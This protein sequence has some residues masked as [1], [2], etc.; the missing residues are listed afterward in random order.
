MTRGWRYTEGGLKQKS[1]FIL[2]LFALHRMLSFHLEVT[3]LSPDLKMW[4]YELC[5]FQLCILRI[6]QRIV[7]SKNVK[8]NNA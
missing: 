2:W 3:R 4:G 5:H 8:Q 1:G 7:Y 6:Q